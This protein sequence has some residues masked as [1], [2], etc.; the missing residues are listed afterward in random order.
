MCFSVSVMMTFLQCCFWN[1]CYCPTDEAFPR[2]FCA[3][4]GEEQGQYLYFF[5]AGHY[6]CS[7]LPVPVFRMY[8]DGAGNLLPEKMLATVSIDGV[9]SSLVSLLPVALLFGYYNPIV[10][11]HWQNRYL[12]RVMREM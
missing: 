7:R 1:C 11:S 10:A 9:P 4:K 2:Y 3:L 5:V 12:L 6:R 8:F